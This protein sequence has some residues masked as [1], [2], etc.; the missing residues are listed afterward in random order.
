VSC[1]IRWRYRWD[2][3]SPVTLVMRGLFTE[4]RHFSMLLRNYGT[5]GYRSLLFNCG[6]F[7][8]ANFP[9]GPLNKN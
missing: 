8:G 3:N 9:P 6:V 2:L 4:N 1:D 7:V 5:F